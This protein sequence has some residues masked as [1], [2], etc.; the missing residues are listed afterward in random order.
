[1]SFYLPPILK[2][3]GRLHRVRRTCGASAWAGGGLLLDVHRSKQGVVV[4]VAGELDI[5]A[6]P[7][8]RAFVT[9]VLAESEPGTCLVVDLGGV[10][11]MDARGLAVLIA[12]RNQVV[13]HRGSMRLTGY[14]RAVARL[15]K[16]TGLEH[17]AGAAT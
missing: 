17:L 1:M 6:E 12:A 15:L 14:S 8:V 16:L 11:F 5:T 7:H 13:A 2:P 10:D 3:M 9:G 4:R